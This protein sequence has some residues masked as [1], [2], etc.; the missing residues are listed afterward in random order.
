[1]FQV[2]GKKL[3]LLLICI[4]FAFCLFTGCSNEKPTQATPQNTEVPAESKTQAAAT[5]EQETLS[6]EPSFTQMPS[7][8]VLPDVLPLDL[9]F[10]SGAGGWGTTITLNPDGSFIGTYRDT[11]MGDRGETYPNGSAYVCEFSGKFTDIEQI[12]EYSYTMNLSEININNKKDS[13]WI[14]D[15][16]RYIPSDPYGL[17]KGKDFI[18]YLPQTPLEGLSEEFLSWW[19]GR[20]LQEEEAPRTL[21]YYGLFNKEMGY[22]FFAG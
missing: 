22:G 5:K 13:E 21:S 9:G 4:V 2:R 7:E 14:Q 11:D 8:D 6:P 10:S 16:I 15:G 3:L 17:E 20:Y 19:P 12:D 1:M 18:F